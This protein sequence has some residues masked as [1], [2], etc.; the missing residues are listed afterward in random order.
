MNKK[1]IVPTLAMIM[2]AG[3]VGSISGTVAWYQYST[4]A[5]IGMMGTSIGLDRNLEAAVTAISA[6]SAPAANSNVWKNELVTQDLY[7]VIGLTEFKFNPVT[8][9]AAYAKDADFGT[10][11]FKGNP[12]KHK[13][14]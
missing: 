9:S 10:I 8:T 14:A 2:G 5:Q 1:I 12:I 13:N 6:T 11:S 7:D 3:L 4:R